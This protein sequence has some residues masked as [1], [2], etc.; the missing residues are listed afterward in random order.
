MHEWILPYESVRNARDPDSVLLAFCQSCYDA[1][2]QL[3]NWNRS[4]LERK[5]GSENEVS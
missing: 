5:T 4:A 3:G 1:A 2:A